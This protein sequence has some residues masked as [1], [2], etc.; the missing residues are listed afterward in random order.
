MQIAPMQR[1]RS[2][3]TQT[4]WLIWLSV[5]DTVVTLLLFPGQRVAATPTTLVHYLRATC[6]CSFTTSSGGVMCG[7][8]LGVALRLDDLAYPM[9]LL[10]LKWLCTDDA[11]LKVAVVKLRTLCLPSDGAPTARSSEHPREA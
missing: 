4:A 5:L 9:G 10:K 3:K 2:Y 8:M 6:S 11:L 1:Q 7:C